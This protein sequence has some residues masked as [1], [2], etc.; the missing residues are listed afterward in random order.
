MTYI[1]VSHSLIMS[2]AKNWCFTINN[3]TGA[4]E[5]KLNT[6]FD[7]GHFSYI[8]FGREVGEQGTPHLQGYVQMK[9]KMRMAQVKKF[10]SGRAHL[11]VSRGSPE[12][13]S[14]YCRMLYD[15]ITEQVRKKV[16]LSRR[17]H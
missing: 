1:K 5:I 2:A 7:H 10:I 14:R 8:I 9:K 4:D 12:L 13:A 3:Y 17:E 6:M 15:D 16:I 11:E